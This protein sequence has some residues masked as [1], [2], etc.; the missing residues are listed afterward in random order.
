M[1]AFF[2]EGVAARAKFNQD[3]AI[4]PNADGANVIVEKLMPAVQEL[5]VR[6]NR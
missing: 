4:H 6:V 3:D 2:L 5:L 1:V